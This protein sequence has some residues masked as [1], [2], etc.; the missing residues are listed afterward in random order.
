MLSVD[1]GAPVPPFEQIRAQLAEQVRSGELVAGDQLPPVRRLASDLGLAPGTVARAYKELEQDGL[2]VT[3][4]RR[5]TVVADQH[6][7]A[8]A[9]ARRH[10]ESFV[11]AMRALG[12]SDGETSRLVRQ[13][14]YG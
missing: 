10:V 5:G 9:D 14:L 13:R 12:I 6:A 1:A 2:V 7:E 8:S 4:G 11:A 3:A